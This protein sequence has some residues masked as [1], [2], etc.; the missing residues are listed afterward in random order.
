MGKFLSVADRRAVSLY[1]L[2]EGQWIQ[3]V[4]F[5][6]LGFVVW[7][8]R[9]LPGFSTGSLWGVGTETWI[10]LAVAETVLHQLYVALC[11]RVELHGEVLTAW[12]GKVAFPIYATGFGVLILARPAFVVA[13]SFANRGTLDI[14]IVVGRSL[15]LLLAI[16]VG[17]TFFS[18]VRTFGFGRA[19]GS[20]HFDS[21]V[22]KQGLVRKGIHRFLPNAMYWLGLLVLWLPALWWRSVAGLVV[23]LFGHAAVWLHY[24]ATERPDMRRIYRCA[25]S[26]ANGDSKR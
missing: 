15:A 2:V 16:P 17:W 9:R 23:A 5:L 4:G 10:V 21:E 25:G 13:I 11:W 24:F 3:V 20:D 1:D 7:E 14:G 12:L 19:A 6:V 26:R 22:R 18:V 8:A